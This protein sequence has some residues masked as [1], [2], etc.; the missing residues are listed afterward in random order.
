MSDIN[1]PVYGVA[2][3]GNVKPFI[4]VWPFGD[5][6]QV[7]QD[8]SE[9]GGDEDWLA[10]VPVELKN[11]YIQWLETG[12]FGWNEISEHPLEDGRVVYIGAHA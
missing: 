11:H 8:L 2:G 1:K 10:L 7:Y 12:P 9:H 6:P 3:V 4:M 5:A